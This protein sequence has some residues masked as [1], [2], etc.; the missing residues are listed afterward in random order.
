MGQTSHAPPVFLLVIDAENHIYGC[1]DIGISFDPRRI[2]DAA[3]RQGAI[4]FAY[5]LGNF[6]AIPQDAQE[7]IAIAG[8]N[9]LVNIHC[10]R[11]RDGSGG[12]DTTDQSL[13]ALV[14]R[15]LR[16]SRLDG[17]I[18]ATDDRDFAPIMNAVLDARHPDTGAP[19]RCIRLSLR[20]ESMLDAIGEVVHLAAHDQGGS[21]RRRWVPEILVEDLRL[22]P[23]M[24]EDERP[25]MLQ[26]MRLRAPFVVGLL[27][28]IIRRFYGEERRQYPYRAPELGARSFLGFLE[29][30]KA[31]VFPNDRAD[32]TIEELRSFCTALIEIGVIERT[33][34]PHADGG[35]RPRYRPNWAH[36]FCTDAVADIA[37]LPPPSPR[38]TGANGAAAAPTHERD[39]RNGRSPSVSHRR[40]PLEPA[41]FYVSNDH[42]DDVYAVDAFDAEHAEHVVAMHIGDGECIEESARAAIIASLRVRTTQPEGSECIWVF[43]RRR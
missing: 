42:N 32:V 7:Q 2:L 10:P 8:T 38:A 41:T 27:R 23:T 30:A 17:V 6:R 9:F 26:R 13:Q 18:F 12:K 25:A 35:T 20:S 33:D 19:L 28:S 14:E 1:R 21:S 36:P 39:T 11:L 4:A 3:R 37:A 31:C 29:H 22:L 5:A 40:K 43:D 34:F 15:H 16:H 24:R